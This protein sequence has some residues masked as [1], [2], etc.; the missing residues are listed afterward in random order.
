[1]M[2]KNVLAVAAAAIIASGVA[3]ASANDNNVMRRQGNTYI[4]NTT[5]LCGQRGYRCTTP[6]E[7]YIQGNKV[8]KVV[9]LKNAETP[10]IFSKVARQ[11]LPQMAGKSLKKAAA[12]DAVSG[13]TMS[14][15]AVKANVAAAV[16][17]YKK[18]K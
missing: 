6:L 11:L 1:M 14:S 17:Y 7:V 16:A 18:H 8:V 15:R 12:V 5:T 10:Q 13:A 2:K 3:L 4:V 9:A